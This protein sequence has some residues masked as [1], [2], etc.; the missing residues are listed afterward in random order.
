LPASILPVNMPAASISEICD[1]QNAQ[2]DK[3]TRRRVVVATAPAD[4]D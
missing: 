1:R 2:Q 4:A 3:I